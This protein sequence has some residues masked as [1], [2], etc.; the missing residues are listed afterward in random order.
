MKNTAY[1]M[2]MLLLLLFGAACKKDWLE[3][4]PKTILLEEQVWN[5]PKQILA[6]LANYY[7][8]L[9]TDMGMTGNW[10]NMADYDDA[11]WSGYSGNDGRN[12][13]TTYPYNRW[14]LWEYELIRD[15][16]LALE[17]IDRYSVSLP[18]D[19]KKQFSAELR[20]LRAY[21]YFEMVKRMGGVPLI[22]KQLIYDY[23]GDPTPLQMPRAKES[24]VYDFIAAEMD[25]IQGDLGNIISNTGSN[26]SASNTRANKYTA[27][28]LKSRAMLYAGSLAK[29]NNIA[30]NVN[31]TLPNGEVGIPASKADAYYQQSLS[32]SKEIISSGFYSL[33]RNNPN[34]GENFYE[35]VV[36][37]IANREAIFVQDFLN[38]TKRHLFS[39]DNIVRNI[40]EDNLSS[41]GITP[42]LGLVESFEYLDG[43]PGTLKTRTADNSDYIYYDKPQDIFA[44]KDAR[45]YGTVIYPGAGFKG[46]TIEMQ[47]GVK[48]WD[49]AAN[50]FNTIEGA[51]LSSNWTDGKLLVGSA[52]P[53]RDIQEVS[54]TGFY[55]R[56]FI[57]AGTGTSTRGIQSTVWWVRF[58]LGE[59]YLNAAEAALE[60]GQ[61]SEALTYVNELRERAGFPANSLAML[62]IDK[63]RNERRVELAF[64][65]HR[66][67]DLKRWRIADKLWNGDAGNPNDMV[68]GLYPYRVVKPGD[69]ARD[70]K[71]VF[72]KVLPPR[73]RAPRFFRI[74][75]YYSQID[76]SWINN[77]PKLVP[78]PNH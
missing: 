3:R 41:S 71:Y 26:K 32:A 61:M 50:R 73:F 63:L 44:N 17:G 48:A 43:T 77:N 39:Y 34:K 55:L 59:I 22:T 21:V 58:R 23:S 40:R 8:R 56:K 27:L 70:G 64:E 10:A 16:N 33:Y 35:A 47:A 12:N 66:V 7:D 75:N 45:L 6:L 68:Y 11:M 2:M 78:N 24:E 15:I 14:A 37:K 76:Q 13:I 5:D 67:W 46:Q 51:D 19:Q 36:N 30:G 60:L 38:P 62:T 54:T 25:A 28:A 9:P 52:G 49:A 42:S 31:I 4:K 74:G 1:Y 29:Y 57:D 20:F 53:H 18:A 72:D 65:D 69:P